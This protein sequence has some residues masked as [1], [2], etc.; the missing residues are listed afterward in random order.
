MEWN[1]SEKDVEHPAR[2]T[3]LCCYVFVLLLVVYLCVHSTRFDVYLP[4]ANE[5]DR[6]TNAMVRAQ[7]SFHFIYTLY[8]V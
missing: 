4:E 3:V 1:V 6:T 8:Y 2:C 7:L 5:Y